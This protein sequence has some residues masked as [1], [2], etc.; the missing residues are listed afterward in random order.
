MGLQLNDIP[1]VGTQPQYCPVQPLIPLVPYVGALRVL[2]V[3]WQFQPLEAL[4][5]LVGSVD[6]YL[7]ET[8]LPQDQE[9]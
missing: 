7:V 3:V 5:I 2:P 1:E 9:R 8:F 6:R 4:G